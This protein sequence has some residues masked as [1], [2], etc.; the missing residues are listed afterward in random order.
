MEGSAGEGTTAEREESTE[1]DGQMGFN[2]FPPSLI[3][4]GCSGAD[5]ER[6]GTVAKPRKM[7]KHPAAAPAPGRRRRLGGTAGLGIQRGKQPVFQRGFLL[8]FILILYTDTQL[9]PG[10]STK[11]DFCWANYIRMDAAGIH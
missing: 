7:Q 5:G 2:F 9:L 11:Y 6:P 8:S 3:K 4:S 10:F 1:D